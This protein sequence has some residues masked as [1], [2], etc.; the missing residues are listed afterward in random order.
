[1]PLAVVLLAPALAASQ[2]LVCPSLAQV[3]QVNACPTDE[4]LRA[5]FLG[6]CSDDSKAYQGQTELCTDFERFR[7]WKNTA[8]WESADGAF[9]GYRHCEAPAA[10]ATLGRMWLVQKGPIRVLQCE[11]SDGTVLSHRTRKT[12]TLPPTCASDPSQCQ[13]SCAD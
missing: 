1:M 2:T 9:G 10:S 8:L 3:R 6:Y 11:Y 4:Q 5:G 12:C 7:H 13:A